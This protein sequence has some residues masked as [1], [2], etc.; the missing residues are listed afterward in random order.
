MSAEDADIQRYADEHGTTDD[1]GM[2]NHGDSISTSRSRHVKLGVGA[3]LPDSVP[4]DTS[5]YRQTERQGWCH[6]CGNHITQTAAKAGAPVDES[7]EYGH[8]RS[9]QYHIYDGSVRAD[10]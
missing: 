9:C 8:E 10:E 1:V 5:K 4:G 6:D 7:E 3:P 2:Q